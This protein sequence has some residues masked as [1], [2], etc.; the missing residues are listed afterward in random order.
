MR[1]KRVKCADSRLGVHPSNET[2]RRAR[3][4][5]A[6]WRWEGNPRRKIMKRLAKAQSSVVVT[7]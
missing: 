4:N 2:I 1:E 5:S 3:L 6:K 7:P